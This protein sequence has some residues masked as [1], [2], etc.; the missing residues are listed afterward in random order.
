MRHFTF[1]TIAKNKTMIII[2]IDDVIWYLPIEPR[3]GTQTNKL[4]FLCNFCVCVCVHE[5]FS[6]SFL[7]VTFCSFWIGESE[8]TSFLKWFHRNDRQ[9][10]SIDD[11]S[12]SLSS[13]S[14]DM[15]HLNSHW[16]LHWQRERSDYNKKIFFGQND[17]EGQSFVRSFVCFHSNQQSNKIQ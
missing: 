9:T 6:L 13:L 1:R 2:I 10:K 11:S 14:L 5:I 16:I 3:R 4:E 17:S 7:L 8:Q 12:L 15:D